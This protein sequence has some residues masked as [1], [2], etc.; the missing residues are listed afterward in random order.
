MNTFKEQA[1]NGFMLAAGYQVEKIAKSNVTKDRVRPPK[2][3]KLIDREAEAKRKFLL[4]TRDTDIH[5]EIVISIS[6]GFTTVEQAHQNIPMLLT[7][8]QVQRYCRRCAFELYVEKK[9]ASRAVEHVYSVTKK[10]LDFIGGNH[11]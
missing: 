3:K 9:R 5:R 8:A 6:K 11:A 10:G 2:A 4:S 1:P 7:K